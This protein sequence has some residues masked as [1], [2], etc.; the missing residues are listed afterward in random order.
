MRLAEAKIALRLFHDHRTESTAGTKQCIL[1]TDPSHVSICTQL[2]G[3][4]RDR[5][6]D[7][8]FDFCLQIFHDSVVGTILGTY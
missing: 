7:Q 8:S 5:Q 2:H 1:K 3:A 6:A 4:A